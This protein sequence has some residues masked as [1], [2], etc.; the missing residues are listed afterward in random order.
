MEGI[1]Q[2]EVLG[3]VVTLQVFGRDAAQDNL[4]CLH[5]ALD[6]SLKSFAARIQ[7]RESSGGAG[8]A[9][10]MASWWASHSN[11]RPAREAGSFQKLLNLVDFALHV[12][13]VGNED[14]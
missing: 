14:L 7:V 11:V 3:T 8:A 12:P 4:A 9:T 5:G 13:L 1:G 2:S 10:A 6:L